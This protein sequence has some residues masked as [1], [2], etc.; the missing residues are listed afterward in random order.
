MRNSLMR[1]RAIWSFGLALGIVFAV[2]AVVPLSPGARA[3]TAAPAAKPAA[4]DAAPAA[5]SAPTVAPTEWVKVCD[6][7]NPAICQV[8][9]DYALTG[10]QAPLGSFSIQT[11][12][13][14]NKFAIGIQ[15][16]LGFLLQAGI[17]ISV[18]GAKKVTAQYVTC[19]PS[20]QAQTYF[21]LAQALTD[22]TFV[23]SLKKGKALQLALTGPDKSNNVLAFPLTTFAQSFDGP[24][25]A[26]LARQREDAAKALADKAKER[27]KQLEGT[28][29]PKP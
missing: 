28:Q 19:L 24:D 6:P 22:G 10:A 29:Q 14:A 15:V 9:E 21:C 4:P 18:D 25:Q 23:D 11:T 2:S 20:P 3:E 7:K 5:A 26:A 27:A 17:P 8:G 12:P 16:P 13:D 1:S